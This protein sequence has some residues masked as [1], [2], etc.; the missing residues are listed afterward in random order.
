MK[1]AVTLGLMASFFF[2]FTFLLNRQMHLSGGSWLWSSSLRYLFM[3]PCLWLPL[4][5]KKQ[6][7]AVFKEIK[8]HPISWLVFSTIGFGLFYAPLCFASAFNASWLTAGTWQITIMAGA[9]MSPLFLESLPAQQKFSTQQ[10]ISTQQK[11]VLVR[12][13]IP[14][15]ALFMS[16]II[17][18]GIFLVQFEEA[19]SLSYYELLSGFLPVILA[20]FAYPFGN[21]KMIEVCQSRL[22]TIQR[23]FGMTLCSM[24]FWIILSIWGIFDVGLPGKIQI[25]QSILVAI[26]SGLIA[27]VLFFKATDLVSPSLPKL[28]IIEATQSGEVLF[29]LLGGI[30]LFHDT[31]PGIIG[32]IGILFIILGMIL[33]CLTAKQDS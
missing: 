6:T 32:I 30:F 21:R 2:S 23:V 4:S 16:M 11:T 13:H 31:R 25:V 3:L 29:T 22:N 9:L 27:T 18:S 5:I 33:N 19:K 12:G 1:K 17:L 24:P 14:K 10:K 28:A 7:G 15:K 8:L 26:F 20:A